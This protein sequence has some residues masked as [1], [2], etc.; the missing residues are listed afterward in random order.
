MDREH[1]ARGCRNSG[2]GLCRAAGCLR[3]RV[4]S[5]TSLRGPASARPTSCACPSGSRASG[6]DRRLVGATPTSG[7]GGSPGT[8]AP[9]RGHA[10]AD[11]RLGPCA[12]SSGS[13]R[14]H[15]HRSSSVLC[16]DSGPLGLER[17][18]GVGWW[19]LGRSA[20]AHRRLG[21]RPLV[22]TRPRLCLDRRRLALG[23]N[24]RS[25][26]SRKLITPAALPRRSPWRPA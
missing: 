7:S 3:P 11:N 26:R 22:A 21:G 19:P 6:P 13:R 16:V 1:G 12:S 20:Q 8:T 4:P 10:P 9:I 24:R 23:R 17:P 14:G 15:S 18:V 2:H 5:S 25:P